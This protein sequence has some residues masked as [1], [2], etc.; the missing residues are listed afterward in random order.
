M[1][2]QDILPDSFD[3]VLL[4]GIDLVDD[5]HIGA[6]QIDLARV[7]GQ[8]VP[9]AVRIDHND[10]K[11]GL[12]ERR[13]IVAAIP[14]NH[15]GFFLGGTQN[16]FVIHTGINHGAFADVRFVLLAFFDR[17]LL[18]VEIFEGGEALDRLRREVAIGHGM[19]D[20]DGLASVFA[21][22]SGNQS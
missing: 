11:I 3:I 13:V 14:Q 17:A 5:E 7:I 2:S 19:P 22:F 18:Q 10:L 21:K 12:V 16:L 9:G 15:V 8:F 20:N 1:L 4:G 6:A